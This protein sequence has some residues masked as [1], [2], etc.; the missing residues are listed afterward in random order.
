M[1]RNG[2][3]DDEDGTAN[4]GDEAYE[5]CEVCHQEFTGICPIASAD[6]PYADIDDDEEDKL[7]DFEDVD[8]LD[9][10]IEDDEEI[11][12]IIEEDVEIPAEDLRDE[13]LGID[14]DG[15]ELEEPVGVDE[16]EE[17]EKPAKKAK[18]TRAKGGKSGSGKSSREKRKK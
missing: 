17:E 10:L 16:V 3:Y 11:E 7:P 12:K 9:G 6:C 2:Y 14:A 13:E 4:A 8:D 5:E 1:T 15:D 18:G